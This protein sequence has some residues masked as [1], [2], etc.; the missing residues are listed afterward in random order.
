MFDGIVETIVSDHPTSKHRLGYLLL[1]ENHVVPLRGISPDDIKSGAK[2]LFPHPEVEPLKH[3]RSLTAIIGC[4]GFDG[5]FG[6]FLHRGWPDF[7]RFLIA[8]RC[9]H[10]VG[11]FP[12]DH[13]GCI[14]LYFRAIFGP[15]PR[16]LAERIFLDL[17]ARPERVFLGYGVNWAAWDAGHGIDAPAAAIASL[18]ANANA[19]SRDAKALFGRR[20][21]LAGQWGFLDDKL[22][23]GPVRKMV[24]K[25]YWTLGSDAGE[26]SG[27]EQKTAAAVQAFRTVFE[28]SSAGWVDVIPYNER[29]VVLRTHDG[30]WDLLWRDYREK[31]PPHAAQVGNAAELDVQDMPLSLM[32]E[33]DRRRLLY[34]RRDVWDEWE[35]HEAEQAFYDRGG[36]IQERS[37]TREVDVHFAWLREQGKLPASEP[38]W[39][40]RPLP[41]GFSVVVVDGHRLAVSEMISVDGFRDMLAESGYDKRQP[42]SDEPWERAN[43]SAAGEAP[44]G[45]SW[46]DA[47]AFCAWK[48]KNIG[49]ALRLP[50]RKELRALRPAF[51]PHYERL[52]S[53][54][55]PWEHFPPRPIA[56]DAKPGPR[57]NV[58]SAVAWSEPRFLA[59]GPGRPE[60]PDNSGLS[61]TSRKRWIED[62]PPRA[63]WKTPIPLVKHETLDFIDAWDAYEWCQEQGWVNGRFW[64]GPIGANSWGAYKNMKIAFR[65]VIDL[66]V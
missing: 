30:G 55:F 2:H 26:R 54:D 36:S 61:S 24:D 28:R 22:V 41:R 44:V 56:S 3:R 53:A 57:R 8:H 15:G 12:V 39:R 10:R 47:Q 20:H 52:A 17:D 35:A 7:E 16:Q 5:D 4:L 65:L 46:V 38:V 11:A 32:T 40:D 51:S 58:P 13:G 6:D 37:T 14:D 23:G 33:S 25:T 48:E 9:T 42:V 1:R 29:L 21:E 45:V 63:E 18:G 59:P 31:E 62:F 49:V 43:G 60:F 34:F 50:T 66:D 27:H 64:E 19:A